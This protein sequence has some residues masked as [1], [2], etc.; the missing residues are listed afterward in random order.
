MK[1]TQNKFARILKNKNPINSE[2]STLKHTPPPPNQKIERIKNPFLPEEEQQPELT[3]FEKLKES[4]DQYVEWGDFRSEK[5]AYR[6]CVAGAQA[7]ISYIEQTYNR[8]NAAKKDAPKWQKEMIAREPRLEIVFK[9]FHFINGNTR[10]YG[11]TRHDPQKKETDYV[12]FAPDYRFM[13]AKTGLSDRQLR[14]YLHKF[15]ELE[16]IK[17]I[18]PG[19]GSRSPTVYAVGLW[20]TYKDPKTGKGGPRRL[21]FLIKKTAKVLRGFKL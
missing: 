14:K 1:Q 7:L 4:V 13:T 11:A 16:L 19:R 8:R 3:L 15:S 5:E 12:H 2:Q 21:F 18:K 9:I 17:V 6:D 20:G 10:P